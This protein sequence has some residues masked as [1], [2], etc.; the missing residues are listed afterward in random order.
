VVV[1]AGAPAWPY[2]RAQE[3]PHAIMPIRIVRSLMKESLST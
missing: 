2:A 3:S 1:P